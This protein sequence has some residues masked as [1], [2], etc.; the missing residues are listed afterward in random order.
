MSAKLLDIGGSWNT[1][2]YMSIQSIPNM[3]N[4]WNVWWVCRP[5]NNWDMYSF[6]ELCTDPC[7]MGLCIIMLKRE[8]MDEWHDNGPQDPVTISLCIQ[9]AIDKMQLCLLSIAYVCPY[10]NPTATMGH[11]VHNV[12]I[13]KTL[14]LTSAICL[15]LLKPGYI[16]K[17][18]TFPACE[19]PS[20]VSI[21]PLKSVT[22]PNCSLVKTLV[23]TTS[24]QMFS[25][26]L[27]R[28][29]S[30]VQ[31]HSFIS[32]RCGWS[33]MRPVSFCRWRSRMWRSCGFVAFV[34]TCDLWLRPVGPT[35][36]FSKTMLEAA[37]GR[38]M[39]IKL[40]GNISVGHFCS[41]H[42]SCMLS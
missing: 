3:L 17:E 22:M 40:S 28:N 37:Y 23:R 5:W 19:W 36:K 16:R 11:S 21:S 20:K 9:I 18:H 6:Q 13:N 31:T 12:E 38:E 2:S 33:Q 35:D 4:G 8:V 10:H 25:D 41:Q 29:S 7:D 26:S 32:C 34:V 39:N 30:V 42:A 14:S 27:S 24:T 15:V 1:L